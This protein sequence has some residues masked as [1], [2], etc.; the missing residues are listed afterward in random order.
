ML[1]DGWKE[2]HEKYL[3]SLGNLTLTGYNP[4]LSNSS[5]ERKKELLHD[6]HLE[7][8]K[9]FDSLKFWTEESIIKRAEGLAEIVAR[10]WPMPSS[11]IQYSPSQEALREPEGLSERQKKSLEYWRHLDS[12]LEERGIPPQTRLFLDRQ[13]LLYYL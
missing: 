7:L 12:R 8:N 13:T 3:H 11:G 5:F 10:L 9:W 6:S 2:I 4:D 1:G